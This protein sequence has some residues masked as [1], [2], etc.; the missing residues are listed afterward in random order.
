MYL[1]FTIMTQISQSQ[2]IRNQTIDILRG[3]AIVSMILSNLAGEILKAPHPILVT[4]IGSLA[5]PLFVIISGYL[6]GYSLLNK[7][8][9][10]SYFLVRGFLTL[11]IGA[12]IDTFLWRSYPFVSVDILYLIGLSI[13]MTALFMRMN[14]PFK[15]FFLF[16]FF[17]IAPILRI[18]LG[19]ADKPSFPPIW[20]EGNFVPFEGDN[21]IILKHWLI[22]G[23]FPIF[24]W[25]GIVFLGGLLSEIKLNRVE[26][27]KKDKLILGMIAI[28][29]IIIGAFFWSSEFRLAARG[30][31]TELFYPP[32]LSY[33]SIF[34]GIILFLYLIV[35]I[36]S[37]S[38]FYSP[39]RIIG[40]SPLLFYCLHFILIVSIVA[41][42]IGKTP[43]K[44]IFVELDIF[45]L[46]FLSI[47]IFCVL[48]GLIIQRFKTKITT[49]PF[50]VKFFIG[51]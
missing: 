8:Y 12:C 33:Y 9:P 18:Q 7:H 41:P 17:A 49:L 24:S 32:T 5:A 27:S 29:L 28:I 45:M 19:Y 3:I 14:I 2:I 30:N 10:F 51:G 50:L 1:N 40:V 46:T 31:Y 34:I 11:F 23:W 36:K 35:D 16:L 48:L 38:I 39:F 13:P 26:L 21:F 42:L 44:E 37:N 6:V 22:D 15:V 43:E 25:T 47:L 4:W 20:K